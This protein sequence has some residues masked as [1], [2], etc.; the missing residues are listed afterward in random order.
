V[1]SNQVLSAPSG[2]ITANG[3]AVPSDFL[4]AGWPSGS[5][6]RVRVVTVDSSW[7]GGGD[8]LLGGAKREVWL[9]N[10]LTGRWAYWDFKGTFR[11]SEHPYAHEIEGVFRPRTES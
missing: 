8:P 10:E 6:P 2:K 7:G 1:R 3:R 4:T 9:H 11:T 5:T